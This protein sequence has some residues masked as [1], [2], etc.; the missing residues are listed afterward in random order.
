MSRWIGIDYGTRRIGIAL[1]DPGESIASPAA[2]LSAS[3]SPH[4]DARNILAW[5]DE[6]EAT[7]VVV[8]LPLNMDGTAGPQAKLSENLAK[9]LE[10]LGTC[11]VHLWDERLSSYQADAYMAEGGIR[12]S[13]R[14]RFRDALAAQIILQSFLDARQTE[15]PPHAEERSD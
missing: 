10:Q 13:R 6:N 2:T 3:G 9:H 14:K 4:G 1:S 11:V 5:A 8:G 12:P 15:Q 7:G